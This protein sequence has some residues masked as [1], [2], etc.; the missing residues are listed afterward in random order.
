MMFGGFTLSSRSGYVHAAQDE[1]FTV[2]LIL[3]YTRKAPFDLA[4][5]DL[6]YLAG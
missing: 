3:N 1:I 4:G 2:T 6:S 5:R